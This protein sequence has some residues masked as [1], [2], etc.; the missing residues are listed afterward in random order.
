LNV[1]KTGRQ[2]VKSVT[3]ATAAVY[4]AVIA[5]LIML[6][7]HDNI[8]VALKRSIGHTYSTV[9]GDVSVCILAHPQHCT[10]DEPE[11]L[12]I[13]GPDDQEA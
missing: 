7:R 9:G 6:A 12:M 13:S 8:N 11:L 10:I 5:L 2:F 1:I 4:E 3:H